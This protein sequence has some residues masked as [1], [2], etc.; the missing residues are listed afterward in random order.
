MA[1]RRKEEQA[2][3]E[4][5]QEEQEEQAQEEQAPTAEEIEAQRQEKFETSVEEARTDIQGTHLVLMHDH[6]VAVI[7]KAAYVA[8]KTA[9]ENKNTK[10]IDSRK[11]AQVRLAAARTVL[12]NDWT[13][14]TDADADGALVTV[15]EGEDARVFLSDLNFGFDEHA[16]AENNVP[17]I[18]KE[19]W[20]AGQSYTRIDQS[21]AKE[22]DSLAELKKKTDEDRAT[23]DAQKAIYDEALHRIMTS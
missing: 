15:G 10:S 11:T 18:E 21:I 20:L 8:E 22:P 2:Q 19:Y 13:N 7:S 23:Y 17:E 16:D 3:E 9:W 5:A 6:E 12:L 14:R 1:K 4:Q